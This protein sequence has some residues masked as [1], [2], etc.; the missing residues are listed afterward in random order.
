MKNSF[1]LYTDFY[2]VLKD[3]SDEQLGLLHRVIYRYVISGNDTE[4]KILLSP[5]VKMAFNFIKLQIDKNKEKWEETKEK[6]AEAG[7]KGMQNRWNED[8]TKIT[9]ITKDNKNNKVIKQ[10]TKIT[11]DNNVIDNNDDIT[12]ITS[13]TDNVN[14]NVNVNDN[15]INNKKDISSEQQVATEPETSP[16]EEEMIEAVIVPEELKGLNL[17][18]NNEK[19]LKLWPELIEAWKNAFPGINIIAEVKAAHAW[20]VAN[21]KRR[22][23]DKARFLQNWMARAQ[24]SHGGKI[25][26]GKNKSTEYDFGGE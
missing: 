8:I 4:A 2:E 20:E 21:P 6:R 11:K 18:E 13:I 23:V 19:L 3:L 15:V 22:K 17:Y 7:K 16:D 10:I 9:N 14:V 26:G 12:K 24:D 25:I 1:V 5:E